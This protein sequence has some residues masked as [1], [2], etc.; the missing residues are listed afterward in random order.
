[1][2]DSLEDKKIAY[3]NRAVVVGFVLTMAIIAITTIIR[4]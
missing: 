3:M 2:Y 1:M 4:A